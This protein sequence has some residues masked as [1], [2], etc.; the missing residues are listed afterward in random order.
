MPASRPTLS[1]PR[2]AISAG[3]YLAASAG[4]AVLEAGGNAVDAG[5]AAGIA[6]GV[7]LPDL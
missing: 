4:Y 6:L 2:H 3:H 7:L 5:C 1:G